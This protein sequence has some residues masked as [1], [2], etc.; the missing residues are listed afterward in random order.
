MLTEFQNNYPY[1]EDLS[2][3][4]RGNDYECPLCGCP[5]DD[6][7][8]EVHWLCGVWENAQA[9]WEPEDFDVNDWD[10]QYY[11]ELKREGAI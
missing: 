1:A 6:E 3:V 7:E 5:M 8:G 10:W 9:S 11:Y 4:Y 2:M